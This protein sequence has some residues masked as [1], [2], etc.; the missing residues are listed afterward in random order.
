MPRKR[1]ARH[2]TSVTLRFNDG[3]DV[4]HVVGGTGEEIM[5]RNGRGLE[6]MPYPSCSELMLLSNWSRFCRYV[7]PPSP[8]TFWST[9]TVVE[10]P[11]VNIAS[12]PVKV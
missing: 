10:I 8:V 1:F 2:V 12:A 7:I 3:V 5:S 4:S 6:V 11:D 9:V